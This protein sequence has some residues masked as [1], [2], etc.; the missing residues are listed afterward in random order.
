METRTR[1]K[2]FYDKNKSNALR[3]INSIVNHQR[4]SACQSTLIT[5]RRQVEFI[6][7]THHTHQMTQLDRP[8]FNRKESSVILVLFRCTALP[9]HS[10]FDQWAVVRTNYSTMIKLTCLR[11]ILLQHSRYEWVGSQTLLPCLRF[12]KYCATH[13]HLSDFLIAPARRPVSICIPAFR[14][15]KIR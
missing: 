6:I 10:T 13:L 9:M 2:Y 5:H 1:V 14:R 12:I 3:F 7:S 4:T 11:A 8:A 15:P